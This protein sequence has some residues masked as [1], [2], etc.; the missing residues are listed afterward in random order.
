MVVKHEMDII[1]T[2]EDDEDVENLSEDSDV[3]VEVSNL[4]EIKIYCNFAIQFCFSYF[5]INQRSRSGSRRSIS[6]MASSLCRRLR[7][8]TKTLGMT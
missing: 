7:S 8:T 4:R 1:K 6:R 2:I 3:E 5:S